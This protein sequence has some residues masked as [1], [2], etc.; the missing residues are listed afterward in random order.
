[1]QTTFTW[2]P[3]A[4]AVYARTFTTA[5]DGA[6]TPLLDAYFYDHPRDDALHY[7]ALL[8]SGGVE[9]GMVTVLANGALQVDVQC[10]EGDAVVQRVKR[11]DF[12]KDFD[13][14]DRVRERV[15]SLEGN[16][17]T[18]MRDVRHTRVDPKQQ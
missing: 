5:A 15:W 6:Q 12:E 2:V 14:D 13:R 17:R 7:L 3:A 16:E 8:A 11:F 1:M 4:D 18:L 10:Y 9:E